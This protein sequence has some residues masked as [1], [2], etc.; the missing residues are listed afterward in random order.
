[1]IHKSLEDIRA[2]NDLM[3]EEEESD[4]IKI[5]EE[6]FALSPQHWATYN[7]SLEL[8][9]KYYPFDPEN[10]KY[11]PNDSGGVYTFVVVPGIAKHP[12]CSYLFY[13]G[14]AQRST[15]LHGRYTWYL[16]HKTDGK[17]KWRHIRKLLNYWEKHLWFCYAA[18]GQEDMIVQV[19]RALQDAYIPPYNKEFRGD[20]G[21]A[22][23]V[24]T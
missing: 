7:L 17:A 10:A 4:L 12:L 24:L 19:E 6:T 1:M 21:P 8:D 13:V 2:S 18:I 22:V 9:W 3:K 16:R 14:K 20:V 5:F 11:I 23:R 15:T